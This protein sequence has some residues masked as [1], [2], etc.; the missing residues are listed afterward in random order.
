MFK[1]YLSYN[2]ALSFHRSCLA[3]GV[4]QPTIKHRLMRSS[5][6]MINHFAKSL[7]TRDGKEESKNFFVSLTCLR[8]CK[9]T[10]DEA[11]ITWGK[12][13]DSQYSVLSARLE[14]LCLNASAAEKGQLRMFG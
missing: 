3:V 5:E 13:L 9:D 7:Y 8:D 4:A 6:A 1:H 12:E 2:L 14:Q 10:L 11:K